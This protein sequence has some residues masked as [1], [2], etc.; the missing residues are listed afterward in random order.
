MAT[1]SSGSLPQ[2]RYETAHAPAARTQMS[3]I[4]IMDFPFGML[5]NIV[6]E[7]FR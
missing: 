6:G 5:R 2:M 1:G 3:E 7:S 4:D